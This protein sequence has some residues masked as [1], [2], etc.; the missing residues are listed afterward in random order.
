M[1]DTFGLRFSRESESTMPWNTQTAMDLKE[2]FITLALQPDANRR[3]LCRRFNISPQTGYKW[4]RRFQENGQDGLKE[5]SRRPLGS[6]HKASAELEAQIVALRQQHPAWGGR[7]LSRRLGESV[8]PSTVTNVLHRH[9]L[10]LPQ[11]SEAAQHWKR[12]ERAAPNDL[13]QM[14]FKGYFQTNQGVCHPLTLIDDHSRFNLELQAC[15]NQRGVLVETHLTELFRRYGLPAQI[16][17]DNGPPWGSPRNPGE[18][19]ALG[20]WLVRLG[21]KVTCSRPGHPQT[22]GKDERFHRSLKAEVLNGQSFKSL[23]ETQRAFDRW[24]YIYNHERPHQALDYKVPMDR[25]RVSPRGLPERLAEVEY[26][27]GETVTK[28]Y[29]SRFRFQKRYFKIAKA[30]AGYPVVIRP[31]RTSGDQ[32]DVYFCHHW[33]RKIDFTAP[34]EFP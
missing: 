28:V 8:A 14:D 15:A 34:E 11:A 30:L 2:E 16:N 24:R 17:T 1:V 7:K 22:N 12:F 4:L 20:I 5:R 33:V 10:I 13:W 23:E 32:F 31:R 9:G 19:T 27:P 3:E 26:A 6:P 18:L 29:H 25:Y 21:I